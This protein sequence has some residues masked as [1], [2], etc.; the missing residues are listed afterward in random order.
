MTSP[1]PTSRMQCARDISSVVDGFF[2]VSAVSVPRSFNEPRC[3]AQEFSTVYLG[4]PSSKAGFTHTTIMISGQYGVFGILHIAAFQPT[5]YYGHMLQRTAPP[6][7]LGKAFREFCWFAAFSPA[8][9][10]HKHMKEF[11][12]TITSTGWLAPISLLQGPSLSWFISSLQAGFSFDCKGFIRLLVGRNW[13]FP[14]LIVSFSALVLKGRSELLVEFRAVQLKIEMTTFHI[15]G[16]LTDILVTIGLSVM[17]SPG[18]MERTRLGRRHSQASFAYCT[19]VKYQGDF[20]SAAHVHRYP[21]YPHRVG[22]DWPRHYVSRQPTKFTLLDY[23]A[24]CTEQSLRHY[25]IRTVTLFG[26]VV[27]LNSRPSAQ[28]DT[29]DDDN[30]LTIVGLSFTRSAS[31]HSNDEAD[32]K[33]NDRPENAHTT[34]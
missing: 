23:I 22:P 4:L 27:I 2:F 15:L 30:N 32:L 24:S 31:L 3:I 8:S 14:G 26:S 7:L 5:R 18:K 34:C 11:R 19:L 9:P 25:D 29:S 13:W 21:R 28:R 33:L 6:L 17:L 10:L 16:I 20:S 1:F 12:L